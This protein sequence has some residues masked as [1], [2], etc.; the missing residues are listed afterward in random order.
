MTPDARRPATRYRPAWRTPVG[1]TRTE[2]KVGDVE[3][4]TNGCFRNTADGF[5][6][7]G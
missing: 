1:E 4:A 5:Q 3:V 2:K 6:R 7:I